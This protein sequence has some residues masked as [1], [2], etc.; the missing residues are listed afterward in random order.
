MWVDERQSSTKKNIILAIIIAILVIGLLIAVLYVKNDT[1]VRDKEL[2]AIQSQQ[3]QEQSEARQE[4][5]TAIQD[6]YDK[7]MQTVADYLPGIVCWG[8]TLTLGD[9]A[10]VSYPYV[11]QKY[12]DTYINDV[13]DF[14]STID[15]ADDYSRLDWDEY[16]VSIPVV[17]MGAG[18]ETSS[19][20][21]GRSGAVPFVTASEMTIPA[22]TTPVTI[23]LV[24]KNG[25]SVNPLTGG[26]AGV[27]NVVIDGIEGTL[28]IDSSYYSSSV[29]SYTFT[30]AEAG[31]EL[32]VPA[33]TVVKTAATDEYTNYIHI[34]CIGTYGGFDT[35]DELVQQTKALVA[36][37]TQNSD[38]FIVLGLCSVNGYTSYTYMMDQIDTA[39]TQAF[40]SRYINVRKYLCGD[41][42]TESGLTKTSSDTSAISSSVLPP[43]FR[44]STNSV[45]LN[46]S[47]NRVLAKAIFNRMTS[48]GYFDEINAELGLTDTIKDITKDNPSYFE[49]IIKTSIS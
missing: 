4:A 29:A 21:L 5:V 7:D 14:R 40:G 23:E 27:N 8:D 37:Q 48:L 41:G 13:Y 17:N 49:N 30:R 11:L 26:T 46:S 33:G 31:A 47:A 12:I 36:R 10:S 35:V 32:V 18:D 2:T 22:G 39:M 28:A 6:E 45:E 19:T 1:A 25:K 43:S 34:V 20:V 38:R 24:S 42:F 44:L 15:D 9:S 16:K 3:Q